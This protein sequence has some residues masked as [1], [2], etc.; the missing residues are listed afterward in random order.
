MAELPESFKELK[1]PRGNELGTIQSHAQFEASLKYIDEV[2]NQPRVRFVPADV[3]KVDGQTVSYDFSKFGLDPGDPADIDIVAAP[4][5]YTQPMHGFVGAP[6]TPPDLV[7]SPVR[8]I[9]VKEAKPGNLTKD[10]NFR[11]VQ[12][13][14][15]DPKVD[16]NRWIQELQLQPEYAGVNLI[17]IGGN[18]I[19]PTRYIKENML[20]AEGG[21]PSKIWYFNARFVTDGTPEELFIPIEF[22]RDIGVDEAFTRLDSILSGNTAGDSYMFGSAGFQTEMNSDFLADVAAARDSLS[23]SINHKSQ[24]Y[25]LPDQRLDRDVMIDYRYG[26]T[27]G[28][29]VWTGHIPFREVIE[30]RTINGQLLTDEET[31]WV[32]SLLQQ[33]KNAESKPEGRNSITSSSW[34]QFEMW[35]ENSGY[36]NRL[37]RNVFFPRTETGKYARTAGDLQSKFNAVK[38]WIPDQINGMNKLYDKRQGKWFL[39]Q[40][41]EFVLI[42]GEAIHTLLERLKPIIY[43]LVGGPSL[44]LNSLNQTTPEE[45]VEFIDSADMQTDY[46]ALSIDD[47][48][49]IYDNLYTDLPPLNLLL[50]PTYGDVFA[51]D[52]FEP[53]MQKQTDQTLDG[54]RLELTFNKQRSTIDSYDEELDMTFVEPTYDLYS[55]NYLYD[56]KSL[57][58]ELRADYDLTSFWVHNGFEYVN[59]P[60]LVDGIFNDDL[61]ITDMSLDVT[62]LQAEIDVGKLPPPDFL[63]EDDPLVQPL[64]R[65]T[66]YDSIITRDR[67]LDIV[68]KVSPIYL[69]ILD[70]LSEDQKTVLLN[71]YYDIIIEDYDVGARIL[72]T[73]TGQN[74]TI[75]ETL[76]AFN[77]GIN[78]DMFRSSNPESYFEAA[79]VLGSQILNQQ[80]NKKLDD[81]NYKSRFENTVGDLDPMF[82]LV[83]ISLTL[84]ILWINR[85]VHQTRSIIILI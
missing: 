37:G 9:K 67:F 52:I 85:A 73:M 28:R 68:S 56:G 47:I 81:Y 22:S 59:K 6:S 8:T 58:F 36:K 71:Q 29:E 79:K 4:S 10:F 5:R 17:P 65:M 69:N 41:P 61:F 14:R 34:Q 25:S 78:L 32:L 19:N 35:F 53:V 26:G 30:G 11:I 66:Y 83:P 27:T 33:F 54:I 13:D 46:E 23:P 80:I 18:S 77:L 1:I 39:N 40:D 7:I 49:D 55:G 72:N 3:I 43:P 12:V 62:S 42:N 45:G 75:I 76:D 21:S 57:N 20:H 60:I 51:S 64:R 31:S 38:H 74:E 15:N 24:V 50:D 16:V 2:T 84:I 63:D 70:N 82:V 48:I 44:Q